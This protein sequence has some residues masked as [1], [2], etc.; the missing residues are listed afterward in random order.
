V[1]LTKGNAKK[2]IGPVAFAPEPILD[3]SPARPN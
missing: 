1:F 3:F 2:K